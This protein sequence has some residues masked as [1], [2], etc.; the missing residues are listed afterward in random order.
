MVHL[1]IFS[2]AFVVGLLMA[3]SSSFSVKIYNS[4]FFSSF[5][6][7]FPFHVCRFL[8]LS[9]MLL[10]KPFKIHIHSER[11]CCYA[12]GKESFRF[13]KQKKKRKKSSI[14][15]VNGIIYLSRIYDSIYVTK[16][17][18]VQNETGSRMGSI[19]INVSWDSRR[20]SDNSG[21]VRL[22]SA[23][24]FNLLSSLWKMYAKSLQIIYWDQPSKI[25][26]CLR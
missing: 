1:L 5:A 14:S 17:K 20:Y 26:R 21:S 23:W 13:P 3:L 12:Q 24:K 4:L 25:S 7:F 8:L 16:P 19:K 11:C 18:T 9:S 15:K 10:P 6:I 22:S 2:A